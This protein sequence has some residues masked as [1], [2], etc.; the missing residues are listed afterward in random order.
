[1]ASLPLL[2]QIDPDEQLRQAFVLERQGQF[3]KVIAITAPL[4]ESS[5]LSSLQRGRAFITLGVAYEG[6]GKFRRLARRS[7]VLCRF[8]TTS[9]NT[10]QTMLRPWTTTRRCIPMLGNRRQ[11][12]DVAEGTALRQQIGDHSG[13][14]RSFVNLAGLAL[15]QNRVREARKYLK[16]AADEM[17]LAHDLVDDDFAV[18]FETEAWLALAEGHPS[19]AGREIRKF[20]GDR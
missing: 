2:A 12:P 16:Q 19:T 18:L 5:Q 7:S 8:L 10:L 13:A 9:P 3:G 4:T 1:M 11:R 17:K 6:E 20:A 14:T 15:A